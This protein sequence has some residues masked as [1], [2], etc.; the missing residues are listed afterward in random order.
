MPGPSEIVEEEQ[1]SP[2]YHL[3]GADRQDTNCQIA[4]TLSGEGVFRHGS[5]TW[6]LAP[7]TMFMTRNNDPRT[8]YYFPPAG[9]KPWVFLWFSFWGEA[10]GRMIDDIA[11]RYGHVFDLPRDL[12]VIG[13]IAAYQKYANGVRVLNPL[14]GARLVV[15]TLSEIV[16]YLEDRHA[17]SPPGEI[18]RKA[19]EQVLENLDR[20]I[21]VSTLAR[22]LRV[23]REHL[24]RTFKGKIG[25]SLHDFI[26]MEKVKL[27]CQLLID[28]RL[29]CKEIAGRCG[30]ENIISFNRAFKS[31]VKRTP[32]ELR[33]SGRM[34]NFKG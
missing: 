28:T 12:A 26:T 14:A 21:S 31:T 17:A 24:S 6:R 16:E 11:E 33:L 34:P 15:E 1:S 32:S 18:I 19:Q 30:Y 7:G 4:Y 10:S 13:K 22:T 9:R 3:E 25:L 2:A 29:S 5:D 23:S 20:D 27:A 8:A